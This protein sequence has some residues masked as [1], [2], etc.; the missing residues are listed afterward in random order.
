ECT[1]DFQQGRCALHG[2][3]ERPQAVRIIWGASRE[4]KLSQK[5]ERLMKRRITTR[6]LKRGLCS[7]SACRCN[8]LGWRIARKQSDD[9]M[10]FSGGRQSSEPNVPHVLAPRAQAFGKFA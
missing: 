3:T 8:L 2:E 5:P 1:D 9:L 7:L 6:V 10:P 4:G